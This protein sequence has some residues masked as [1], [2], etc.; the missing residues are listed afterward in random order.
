MAIMST[1]S[2]ELISISS[3]ATYDVYK[4]YFRPDAP[5]KQLMRINYFS[6]TIFALLMG[7]FSTMLYCKLTPC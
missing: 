1:Y 2:S 4:M 7:A 5:G 3:I 6:M